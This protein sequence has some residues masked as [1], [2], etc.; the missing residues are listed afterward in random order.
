MVAAL[1]SPSTGIVDSQ[2]LMLPMQGDL[3]AHGGALALLSPAVSI[4]STGESHVVTGGGDVPMALAARWIV[5]AA[6]L[7]A[8]ALAAKFAGLAPAHVPQP[9]YAK[10]NYFSLTGRAPFRYLI[11][12]IPEEAGLGVHLTLDL[13]GQARFGPD[14]EWIESATP[15]DID[16]TVDARC[17]AGFE[18]AIR[19]C[20]PGLPSGAL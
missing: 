15:D 18:A 8:P 4:D 20:W 17:A 9:R 5:N 3:E 6:G 14:M 7:W 13:A 10:D 19:T 11:Y 12:P 1:H 2:A 16:Y